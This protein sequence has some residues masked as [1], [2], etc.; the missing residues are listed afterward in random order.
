MQFA[1]E[2]SQLT[3]HWWSS[4]ASFMVAARIES[5]NWKDTSANEQANRIAG[6]R[7]SA[8]CEIKVD[9]LATHIQLSSR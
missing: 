7:R 2:F 5:I 9:W 6:V 1:L 4:D 8:Q 3:N